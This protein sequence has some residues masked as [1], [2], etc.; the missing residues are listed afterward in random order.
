LP[1]KNVLLD[2]RVLVGLLV[3]EDLPIANRAVC[4]TT[5]YF[6][7]RACRAVVAGVGG[8]L[9]GP[10]ER[11]D[12]NRRVAA[13][14]QML[15]LPDDV[16]LPNPRQLVPVMLNVHRRHPNLGILNAEATAAALML[17]A[18]MVLSRPTA[19]GQLAS[20]LP[21]EGITFQTVDLP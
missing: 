17:E 5:M 14:D 1:S 20:V 12:P 2:D 8:H 16:G 10:F 19:N 13:L 4:F 9:S 18:K 15:T 21:D 3:G 7:F 11:L 6:Y